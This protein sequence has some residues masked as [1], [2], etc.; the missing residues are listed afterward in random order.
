MKRLL[1]AFGD[2][3]TFGSEL[4]LPRQQP[5]PTHLA[6]KL[7][8][9]AIN[10]GTPA[11][12]IEHTLV[13]LFDWIGTSGNYNNYKK[14]FMVGLSGT[15]R[16]LTY[17]NQLKEFVNITPEANYRTGNIHVSGC[18]PEVVSN[19][20]TLSGEMYRIVESH[21][22]NQYIATKTV[23]AFQNYCAQNNIDVLFFSYFDLA[24]VDY[25]VV[26]SRIIYPTTITKALTGQEYSLP[27]I[28]QHPYFVGK[29]FHPN[30]DG[31]KQIAQILY[32]QYV[33]TYS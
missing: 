15:T 8:A 17:S 1:V 28:C 32:D 13:K 25:R 11:S 12:G 9:E 6:E 4:D 2:S 7:S 26:D 5:W 31:H 18:P 3:W 27:D 33:Q 30:A 21:E 24:Q 20:G 29:L 22:Y 16:Y 14:I 19:F 10:L 23:F